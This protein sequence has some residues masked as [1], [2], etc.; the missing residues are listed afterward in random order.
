MLRLEAVGLFFHIMVLSPVEG[1]RLVKIIQTRNWLIEDMTQISMLF[2][3]RMGMVKAHKSKNEKVH[4]SI[5]RI[6]YY[7]CNFDKTAIPK[8]INTVYEEVID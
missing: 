3:D 7:Y 6:G 8:Y 1:D 5:L 2:Q 4:L